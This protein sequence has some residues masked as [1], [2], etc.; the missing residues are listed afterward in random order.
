[1]PNSFHQRLSSIRIPVGYEVDLFSESH[2]RGR[3]V[4]L[5]ADQPCTPEEWNNIVASMKIYKNN[6]GYAPPDNYDPWNSNN[7]SNFGV[8]IYKFC[9]YKGVA[10]PLSDGEY[11]VL[12][13]GIQN[14]VLSIKVPRRKEVLL[15]SGVN[16]TG[17]YLQITGDRNCLLSNFEYMVNSIKIRNYNNNTQPISGWNGGVPPRPAPVQTFQEEVQVFNDCYYKGKS[18]T[19]KPGQYPALLFTFTNNISSIKVPA[20]R[21]IILYTGVNYRGSSYILTSSSDCLIGS[22]NDRI[23]SVIVEEY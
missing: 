15:Y 7:Q 10:T 22:F 11:S 21:R 12:P 18:F 14:R 3:V 5:R 17:S 20:N 23:R 19:Y 13:M 4:R 16:F 8:N 2:Y 6:S 1:M 9:E